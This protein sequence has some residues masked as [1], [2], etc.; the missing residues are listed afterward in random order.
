MSGKTVVITPLCACACA[1]ACA[2]V[3]VWGA[4]RGNECVKGAVSGAVSE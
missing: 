1:C 3:C 2:C 4:M